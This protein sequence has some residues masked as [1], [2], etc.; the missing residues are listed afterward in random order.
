MEAPLPDERLTLL[1]LVFDEM[2]R[3]QHASR[4]RTMHPE[5]ASLQPKS[6]MDHGGQW[7]HP[8]RALNDELRR[9]NLGV[10]P[11]LLARHA[12]SGSVSVGV[13]HRTRR[14]CLEH[15]RQA[16]EEARWE[17]KE[18]NHERIHG[19]KMHHRRLP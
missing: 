3:Q 15:H 17:Q 1:E 19:P 18:H 7:H 5:H 4:H 16:Q 9:P 14:P 13:I 6:P 8:P 2:Q 11:R 12:A 10:N